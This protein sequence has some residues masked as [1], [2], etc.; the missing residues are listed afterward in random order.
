MATHVWGQAVASPTNSVRDDLFWM[1]VQS[2]DG[3]V[4]LLAADLHAAL[5]GLPIARYVATNNALSSE[6][7]SGGREHW[8]PV[9]W[10]IEPRGD[11]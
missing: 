8:F 2:I 10:E 5:T 7:A 9:T 11:R 4:A 1:D 3:T 6:D